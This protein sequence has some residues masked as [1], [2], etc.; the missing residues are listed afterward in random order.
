MGIDFEDIL[1]VIG[2]IAIMVAIGFIG[3]RIKEAIG[4]LFDLL[5]I[6]GGWA[7]LIW[8]WTRK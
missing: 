8:I 2:C 4:W 3:I 1:K 6:I 5:C 7:F